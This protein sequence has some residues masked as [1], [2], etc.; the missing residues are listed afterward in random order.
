MTHVFYSFGLYVSL[1]PRS[2][3]RESCVTS[4]EKQCDRGE[5]G[6]T[7]NDGEQPL[8]VAFFCPFGFEANS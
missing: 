7:T 6:N 4:Q 2:G 5:G 3:D 1:P 8:L